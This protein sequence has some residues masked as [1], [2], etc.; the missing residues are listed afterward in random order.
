MY[1]IHYTNTIVVVLVLVVIAK[2]FRIMND[3]HA[4]AKSLS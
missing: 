2:Y 1:S 3:G 4:K